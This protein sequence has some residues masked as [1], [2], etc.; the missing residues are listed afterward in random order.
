[1]LITMVKTTHIYSKSLISAPQSHFSRHYIY[2]TTNECYWTA[3]NWWW[4]P[5]VQTII[6]FFET[7]RQ[8][9]YFYEFSTKLKNNSRNVHLVNYRFKL[10]LTF[11]NLTQYWLRTVCFNVDPTFL[12]FVQIPQAEVT[13]GAIFCVDLR[14]LPE[15]LHWMVLFYF[16]KLL[17][18]S[19]TLH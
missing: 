13:T 1:M 18:L 6:H 19:W 2:W 15:L 3:N 17:F 5:N 11:F 10:Q 8:E 9:F 12:L 7:S 4:C 16:F 14:L